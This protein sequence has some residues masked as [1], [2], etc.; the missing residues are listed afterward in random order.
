M[1]RKK[2]RLSG[3]WKTFSEARTGSCRG[4]V[5]LPEEGEEATVILTG[6]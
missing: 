1:L 3:N 4:E 5:F 2:I 6:Q